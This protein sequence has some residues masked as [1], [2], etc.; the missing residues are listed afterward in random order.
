MSK[1]YEFKRKLIASFEKFTQ[2]N[3]SAELVPRTEI[4]HAAPAII[5]SVLYMNY[6]CRSFASTMGHLELYWK[7]EEIPAYVDKSALYLQKLIDNDSE[8]K[9]YE[10]QQLENRDILDLINQLSPYVMLLVGSTSNTIKQESSSKK[11]KLDD[12]DE[13]RVV[14]DFSFNNTYKYQIV[15]REHSKDDKGE[16][17]VGDLF[18]TE[19][20]A[21]D[22]FVEL[23][24]NDQ[25]ELTDTLLQDFCD[26][27][28]TFKKLRSRLQM[29]AKVDHGKHFEIETKE[30]LMK[31]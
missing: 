3:D 25:H 2:E 23:L 4:V 29:H 16:L 31:K 10:R 7:K 22:D 1:N 17:Y 6:F 18:D 20:E 13:H 19:E 27:K 24:M 15:W 12:D 8:L 28:I 26:E 5:G 9:K 30:H 11:R 14:S 21:Q